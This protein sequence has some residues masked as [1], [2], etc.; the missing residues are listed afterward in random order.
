MTDAAGIKTP[1]VTEQDWT[2]AFAAKEEEAFG[3]KFTADVVLEAAALLRPV[4]GRVDVQTCMGTASRYYRSLVF[5][6]QATN[7][8][9]TYV[10]WE[11]VGASGVEFSGVTV[12]T[13][14]DEGLI[15]HVAISHRPLGATLE[16]SAEMNRLTEGRIEPGHFR[17]AD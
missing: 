17:A 14:N 5:T 16:F 1:E 7:G 4:R 9:R 13:R 10:E 3:E 6:H 15:Q 11:A 8:P 12:L 2:G